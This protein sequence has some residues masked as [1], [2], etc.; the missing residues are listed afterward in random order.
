MTD[1]PAAPGKGARQPPLY[2]QV[3]DA[4]TADIRGRSLPAHTLYLSEAQAMREF[5]VSR[6]TIRQ[7]FR[8]LEH[9]SLIYRVHGKGTFVAPS[10]ADMAKSVAFLATCVLRSGV[11]TIMLRSVEEYFDSRNVNLVICNHADSFARAERQVRRLASGSVDGVIYMPVESI[12]EYGRNARVLR[13]ISAADIP[14]LLIDRHV[15]GLAGE[16]ASVRP[17][18]FGGC[19]AMTEH[20]LRLGHRRLAFC[21]NMGSTAQEDRKAGCL[22]ALEAAGLPLALDLETLDPTPEDYARFARALRDAPEPPS[23]AVCVSDDVAFHLIAALREA[24]L[25]VPDDIA[26]VGFDDYS[27][28][29]QPCSGLTT[30]RVG[31]WEKG[32]IAAALMVD[33]LGGASPEPREYVL[34]VELVVRESCGSHIL[35][36]RMAAPG[37]GGRLLRKVP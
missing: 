7:A 26:V 8:V 22:S 30:V 34:P 12:T 18:N 24:G 36:H 21:G 19:K 17:D 2:R 20:L 11:E 1:Q 9:E 3:C 13:S 14:C 33:L 25:A 5:G 37:E 28:L 10:R 27:P 15:P 31:H 35:S 29:G 32:R 23:A 4:I 6:V 16:F